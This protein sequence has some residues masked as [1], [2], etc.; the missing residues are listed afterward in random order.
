MYKH[1]LYTHTRA[2]RHS[3]FD[4]MLWKNTHRAYSLEHSL[5]TKMVTE[6]AAIWIDSRFKQ[7]HTHSNLT[8]ESVSSVRLLFD[9]MHNDLTTQMKCQMFVFKSISNDC[10]NIYLS[11]WLERFMKHFSHFIVSIVELK[12][13]IWNR[14]LVWIFEFSVKI[15][16]HLISCCRCII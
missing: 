11:S 7:L 10:S 8:T 1:K 2:H 9:F 15:T 12:Y 3:L 13:S 4:S 14:I 5:K 6:C 16:V